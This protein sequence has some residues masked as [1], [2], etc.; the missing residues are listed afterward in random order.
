M[1]AF[2]IYL[3][4]YYCQALSTAIGST[5]HKY[6]AKLFHYLILHEKKLKP[7][8]VR[9]FSKITQILVVRHGF[10]SRLSNSKLKDTFS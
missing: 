10:I 7:E 1:S 5:F 3:Y 4:V 2:R 9:K 8:D 6:F